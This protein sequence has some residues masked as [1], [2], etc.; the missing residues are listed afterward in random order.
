MW[1]KALSVMLTLF[2]VLPIPGL[3]G[4][5]EVG[6]MVGGLG[7]LLGAYALESRAGKLSRRPPTGQL[8]LVGV[9][10]L[11]AVGLAMS[12]VGVVS[13]RLVR[14]LTTGMMVV[15]LAWMIVGRRKRQS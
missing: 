2:L 11:A 14:V 1:T 10:G 12:Q 7:L 5:V 6:I 8:V 4:Q 13:T 15:G 3:P 9:V